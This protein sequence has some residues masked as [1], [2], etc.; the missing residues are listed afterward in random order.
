MAEPPTAEIELEEAWIEG[1]GTARWRSGTA[2]GAEDGA[3]ASGASLLEIAPGN[4]LPRHTD[5]AEEIIVVTAGRARVA[6][7][8]GDLVLGVGAAAVVP[9]TAPHEVRNAGRELL[10]FLAVYAS[11]DVVTT[12]D[13]EVQPDGE[14]KRKPLG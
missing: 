7:A 10:R 4:R 9:A 2:L 5:S 14:R 8:D 11:A 12:Y 3:H 6:I 1:D 13:D